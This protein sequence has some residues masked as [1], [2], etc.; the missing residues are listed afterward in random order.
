MTEPLLNLAR[1]IWHDAEE[2]DFRWYGSLVV[3]GPTGILLTIQCGSEQHAR[4]IL[5]ALA[6]EDV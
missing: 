6:R 1:K 3:R 2:A 5:I 4:N